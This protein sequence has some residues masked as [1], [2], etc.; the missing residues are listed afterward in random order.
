MLQRKDQG[1]LGRLFNGV[2][3]ENIAKNAAQRQRRRYRAGVPSVARA[4]KGNE[5]EAG[6]SCPARSDR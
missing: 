5:P 6:D 1:H 3:A 4:K 2:H